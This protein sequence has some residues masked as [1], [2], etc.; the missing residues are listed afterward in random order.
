M[1]TREH[2]HKH[3]QARAHTHTK[4]HPH[5]RKH[6]QKKY[7]QTRGNFARA[8]ESATASTSTQTQ[9]TRAGLTRGNTDSSGTVEEHTHYSTTGNR[10]RVGGHCR[11]SAA[12]SRPRA[13]DVLEQGCLPPGDRRAR[14]TRGHRSPARPPPSGSYFIAGR[15]MGPRYRDDRGDRCETQGDICST[16]AVW[17][18]SSVHEDTL[19]LISSPGGVRLLY[20]HPYMSCR[21]RSRAR[22][23]GDARQNQ[24][25]AYQ[26]GGGGRAG[27]RDLADPPTHPIPKKNSS[28]KK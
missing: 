14:A 4:Q 3:R 24:G 7:A 20:M 13:L 9:W 12:R 16:S 2:M 25:F 27:G 1:R 18:R 21:G 17:L 28:E 22:R 5:S 10:Q 6:V 26:R 8:R 19:G 15:S 23:R 11:R